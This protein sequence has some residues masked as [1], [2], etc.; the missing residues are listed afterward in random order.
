MSD[1]IRETIRP[2]IRS[3]IRSRSMGASGPQ[4]VPD[5][6]KAMHPTCKMEWIGVSPD[7]PF[8]LHQ[9][10]REGY[11]HVP[12]QSLE[13]CGVDLG[14]SSFINS[15]KEGDVICMGTGPNTKAYLMMIEKDLHEELEREE[16]LES[17][18]R[19]ARLTGDV[20]ENE[21]VYRHSAH[22]PN[23]KLEDLK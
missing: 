19:Q 10:V 3:N 20:E 18:E 13:N 11:R 15:Y 23:I 7:N 14:D 16:Q 2:K 6:L 4:H 8:L 12:I 1:K 22:K 9:R 5:E 21:H 17:E